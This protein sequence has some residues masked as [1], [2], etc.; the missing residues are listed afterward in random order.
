MEQKATMAQVIQAKRRVHQSLDKG[1]SPSPVDVEILGGQEALE[2]LLSSRSEMK[3]AI[4]QIAGPELAKT[5]EENQPSQAWP[6]EKASTSETGSEP[7]KPVQPR[8]M[9]RDEKDYFEFV[10]TRL[11]P[12]MCLIIFL[13]VHDWEKAAYY[14]FSPDECEKMASP[15]SKIGPRIEKLFHAPAWVHTV[16]TTSDD[17]VTLLFVFA[18]YFERIVILDKI[19]PVFSTARK[20][21]VKKHEQR[22]GHPEQVQPVKAESNGYSG[23]YQNVTAL[24]IGSQ[25]ASDF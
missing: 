2:T 4:S 17:T 5:Q 19:M 6:Q 18:S 14:A 10:G 11:G 3:E 24:P 16:V 23:G 1:I 8:K 12:L 20:E 7:E 9:T 13:V 15:L 21:T 25:W 22:S